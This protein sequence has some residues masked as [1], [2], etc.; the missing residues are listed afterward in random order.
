MVD[1]ALLHV[2]ALTDLSV[3][4]E[5]IMAFA[6]PYNWNRILQICRKLRPEL[7]LPADLEDDS[8][9]LSTVDT[10]LSKKLLKENFGKNGFIP[11]EQSLKECLDSFL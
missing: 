3:N 8:K 5:R 6:E 7:D 1:T 4:N 2:A 11:L 10:E 9:D